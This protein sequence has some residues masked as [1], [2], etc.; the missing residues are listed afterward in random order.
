MAKPFFT[1]YAFLLAAIG[2]SAAQVAGLIHFYNNLDPYTQTQ[3]RKS[4][5]QAPL[6]LLEGAQRPAQVQEYVLHIQKGRE[7]SRQSP[8][9]EKSVPTYDAFTG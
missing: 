9:P 2:V 1:S 6:T 7:L 4:L 5:F 8:A 3:M